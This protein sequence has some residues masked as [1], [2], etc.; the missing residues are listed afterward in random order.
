MK[1]TVFCLSLLFQAF[2]L[3]SPY[4]LIE[5]KAK[6]P[7]LN[8]SLSERKTVKIQLENGLQAYLVSDPGS[9]QSA[10]GLSVE[11]GSWQDPKEYPGMAHFLEHMLFMGTKAYP[12]EFE[13]MQYIHEHGG[14]VNASTWPDRTIYMFSINN[15]AFT[16]ALDRFSHFFIDPLFSTSSIGRELHAVD[17]EHAKNIE[18]DGWRQYM[19]FKETG[20]QEHPNAGFSTGSAETLSGIPQSALKEWYQQHYSAP[21]MHLTVISPLPLDAL[22]SLVLDCFSK[23]PVRSTLV[24][25]QTQLSLS[26]PKQKGHFIAIKPIKDLRTLS[27]TWEVPPSFAKDQERKPAELVA[28]ALGS[29]A[30]NSLIAQLKKEKIAESLRV[31]T[32]RFNKETL[33]FSIDIVLTPYGLTQVDTAILRTFQALAKAKA[34]PIPFYLFDEMRRLAELD[35]QYQSRDNAYDFVETHAHA[36]IDEPLETYPEKT[37][38]PS[39][40]DSAFTSAFLRT[41]TADSCMIFLQADPEAAGFATEMKEKWTGAEYVVKEL[42]K[43]K[44]TA[45]NTATAHPHIDIT[46]SNPFIPHNLQVTASG[47]FAPLVIAN[48]T[49]GTVYF[50]SDN[51]YLVPEA[52]L[53]FHFKTP[54]IN[55]SASSSVLVDLYLKTLKEKLASPLC[56]A[57]NAGLSVSFYAKDLKLSMAVQG[58]SDKAS[59][60]LK[61]IFNACKNL[62][63]TKEQFEIYKQTIQTSY[64][65]RSKELPLMQAQELLASILFSDSPTSAEKLK[66]LKAISYEDF[67]NFSKELLKTAY[68]QGF[69]YGN[70]KEDEARALWSQ[71]KDTLAAYAYPAPQHYKKQV[72]LLPAK[73]KPLMIAQKTERQGNGVLLLLGE[74]PFSF[75]KR[76]VQQ[77]LSKGLQDGFFETLRTKQQ[78][79]YLARSTDSEVERQLFQSFA[80]QSSTHHTRDLLARFELFLEEFTRELSEKI[81]EERFET[82]RSALVATLKMPPENL[83]LMGL[84]LNLLA[85]DYD[86]DFKWIDKRIAALESLSYQDFLSSASAFLSRENSRRLAILMEGV[87][88]EENDFHYEGV[89]KEEVCD[90]GTYVSFR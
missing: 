57:E 31:S 35:Y 32:D 18:N 74:G 77:I 70:L 50:A 44:L 85:F 90:L 82:L 9:D 20:N 43:E 28:Y 15:D 22:T 55:G 78:T 2:A 83:Q 65:N 64:E 30:E 23:V 59:T 14:Q 19:I 4:Q 24:R 41:L 33:L 68:V 3:A 8:P 79:A 21:L 81:S 39:V 26:S 54:L 61:T 25:K 51:T 76:A 87:L 48:D 69:L 42:S 16:G 5:N 62:Q 66:S 27:L 6:L 84:R 67:L 53:F 11:A 45:W 88:A 60:L 13:Y 36:L 12:K 7:L 86:G 10:A 63:P 29:E 46:P 71:L 75:E 72:L 56:F 89:S 49:Y 38:L 73:Q 58:Y 17:Q 1:K 37:L 34:A 47:C 80:V 40:Y 52:S